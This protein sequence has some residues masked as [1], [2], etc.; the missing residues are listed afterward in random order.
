MLGLVIKCGF[1]AHVSV[2]SCVQMNGVICGR[3]FNI[4]RDS[5]KDKCDFT[6][7]GFWEVCD[8]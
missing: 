4:F 6:V 8:C 1:I 7:E 5:G 3:G 2:C